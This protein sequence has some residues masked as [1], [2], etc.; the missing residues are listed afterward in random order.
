MPHRPST[1]SYGLGVI[2]FDIRT[3]LVVIRGTL[4][5]QRLSNTSLASQIA[6][7]LSNQACLGYKEKE[8]V[9]TRECQ[10]PDPT[11]GASIWQEIPQETIS[12]LYHSMPRRLAACIQARSGSTPY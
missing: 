5:A 12:V 10:W 8:T 2:S 4:T 6:R 7:S 1:R 11:I 9:S 3:P